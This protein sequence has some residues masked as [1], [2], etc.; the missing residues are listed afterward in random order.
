MK[1]T[2]FASDFHLGAPARLSSAER[3]KLIVRWFRTIATDAGAIYLLG[4]LFDFWF[5]YRHVVPRGHTRLLGVLAEMSDAGIPIHLFTGNH[6][7]WMKDYLFREMNIQIWHEPQKIKIREKTFLIGHGDGLGP[8]DHGYKR[9]KKLFRNPMAQWLFRWI[10]PDLG[11]ALANYF[12]KTSREQQEMVQ[13]YLGH[14]RE[15]LIHFVENYKQQDAVDYFVFGHRHIPI[16]YPLKNG[17]SRYIN[18][19]DWLS[20]QSYGVFDGN[21]LKLQFFENEKGQIYR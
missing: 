2:Y 10:H 8:G 15:W 4:D 1:K 19:G 14:D 18:L 11:I 5:D 3:E 21:A 6:D 17:F 7:M 12:S 20:H 13:T 9:L 16:D